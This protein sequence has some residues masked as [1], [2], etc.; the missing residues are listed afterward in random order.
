MGK[1][2]VHAHGD[3]DLYSSL[4]AAQVLG[5]AVSTLNALIFKGFL[6]P[7]P[8]ISGVRVWRP[9][10]LDAARTVLAALAPARGDAK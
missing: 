5:V 4:E 7:P 6:E 3:R 8:V 9:R 2:F 10:D 1:N